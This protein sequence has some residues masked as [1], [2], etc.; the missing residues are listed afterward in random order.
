MIGIVQLTANLR[1]MFYRGP[2][3]AAVKEIF[4]SCS[5]KAD[6]LNP[7][8]RIWLCTEKGTKFPASIDLMSK[9]GF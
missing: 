4:I 7:R 3:M 5:H 1:V 8:P 6:L 9:A 2:V